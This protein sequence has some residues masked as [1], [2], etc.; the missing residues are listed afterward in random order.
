[1]EWY[2][3]ALMLML[4]L[5]LMPYCGV[6]SLEF[7]IEGTRSRSGKMLLPKLGLLSIIEADPGPHTTAYGL[8]ADFLNA[9]NG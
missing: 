3:S 7:F 9:V 6:Q 5:V 4:M 1:M 2:P 8:L